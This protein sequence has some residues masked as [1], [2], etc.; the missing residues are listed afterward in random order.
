MIVPAREASDA[1]AVAAA[2]RLDQKIQ[3][4]FDALPEEV[5]VR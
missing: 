3:A 2:S 1:E 4:Q 5:G